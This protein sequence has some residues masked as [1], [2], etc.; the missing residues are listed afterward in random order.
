VLT[1]LQ[2]K[3][4]AYLGANIRRERMRWE[5]TQERLAEL[6]GL[7][8]RTVQKIEGGRTN[9]LITTTLR[10]KKA[11]KCDWSKLLPSE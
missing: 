9:I 2:Q 6:V 7:N 3:Q 10:F 1:K 8:V 4:L 11:L 5:M